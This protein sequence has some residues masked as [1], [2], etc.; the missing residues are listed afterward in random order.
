MS[1]PWHLP[2]L[3]ERG[4]NPRPCSRWKTRQ[5]SLEHI[6]RIHGLSECLG[7]QRPIA[8]CRK[9][10][11]RHK[12]ARPTRELGRFVQLIPGLPRHMQKI[13]QASPRN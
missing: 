10:D 12:P 3:G 9:H 8:A 11:L 13:S 1:W 4:S 5:L 6:R 2:H 7:D